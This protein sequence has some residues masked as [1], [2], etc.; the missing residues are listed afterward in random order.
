MSG[1]DAPVAEVVNEMHLAESDPTLT[2]NVPNLS[3][4][5]PNPTRDEIK[6]IAVSSTSDDAPAETPETSHA[7][8]TEYRTTAGAVAADQVIINHEPTSADTVHEDVIPTLQTQSIANELPDGVTDHTST[9]AAPGNPMSVLLASQASNNGSLHPPSQPQDGPSA[10]LLAFGHQLPL[11]LPPVAPLQA[12]GTAVHPY[13]A[14]HVATLVAA[15]TSTI[16]SPIPTQ[17][18]ALPTGQILIL[19]PTSSQPSAASPLT[20]LTS[21]SN[22]FA[23]SAP[24]VSSTQALPAASLNAIPPAVF[25][26][27]PPQSASL[28]H[29]PRPNGP[30]PAL[31][32][33]YNGTFPYKRTKLDTPLA[34]RNPNTSSPTYSYPAA[35]STPRAQL[36]V[37]APPISLM[38]P[39]SLNTNRLLI[40]YDKP[41]FAH[42]RQQVSDLE[43]ATQTGKLTR[44]E[45]SELEA[46]TSTIMLGDFHYMNICIEYND[47]FEHNLKL[48]S[49]YVRKHPEVFRKVPDI[50][51]HVQFDYDKNWWTDV[52]QEEKDSY[53]EFLRALSECC[54]DHVLQ[55]SII[56]KYELKTIYMTDKSELEKL[57][58]EIQRDLNHWSK[59]RVCD[60]GENFIRFFPGV[61]FPE[62]L[63]I[64]NIG[65]GYSLETLS[66]FKIPSDLKILIASKGCLTSIDNIVFP[67]SLQR[68]EL[69][70]NKIYFINYAQLPAGLISLDLS[71]NR[72][73]NLRGVHFP[74]GLKSLSLA[75]NPIECIKGAKF[76]E[77]LEYLNISHIPNESMTGVKFPD[78]LRELNLQRS[79]TT[80]R[81]LKLSPGLRSLNL[82]QNGVNSIN[83]LKLPD[84]IE[85]LHLGKNNIKTLNKVM[86][87]SRLEEL[88]L[89]DNLITTLKNIQ[90][91]LHLRIL[92]M[93]MD[94]EWEEHDK[95]ITT[96]KDVVLPPTLKV[97]RL[98]GHKI[99]SLELF[100]FPPA[101]EHLSLACNE[102]RVIRNIRFGRAL[103]VLDLSGNNELSGLEMLSLPDSVTDLRIAEHQVPMLPGY[104]IER[105]NVRLLT[106]G[107]SPYRPHPM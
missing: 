21:A 60:Y 48:L 73:D 53:Y 44:V 62:S 56:N 85:K 8:I 79:M 101:L 40:L 86:F 80:T 77:L 90:F 100:E 72:I 20:T 74:R 82:A 5:G 29:L 59:L 6:T 7:A 89:G 104:V 107:V 99:K 12:A 97:L 102:L 61:K 67:A 43:R 18:A 69:E 14:Q 27:P 25:P 103:Q 19:P 51:Y 92:D 37:V 17:S 68:L 94:P 31:A 26:S 30:T 91:P 2:Q 11:S 23:S 36:S 47:E 4:F 13:E 45:I 66:G 32:P 35:D 1:R 84:S 81:G 106:I 95:Y 105:A 28:N 3:Q 83:P 39:S 93:D 49:E 34:Y 96:L 33:T 46:S 64:L 22:S 75:A 58:A 98:R 24:P 52:K 88:Y 78:Y 10:S 16:H 9:T 71:Q 70:D 50:A 76:P 38:P 55:C 65:G 41:R 15:G 54:G 57:G 63:E 87:P 42:T